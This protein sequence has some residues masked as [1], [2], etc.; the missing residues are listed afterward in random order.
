[1]DF[2]DFFQQGLECHRWNL[3][4]VVVREAFRTTV[5]ACTSRGRRV[6][7]WQ[8]RAFIY[9]LRG[10]REPSQV[11]RA[12][13]YQWPTPTDPSWQ[14]IAFVYRDGTVE[15]DWLHPVSRRFWTDDNDQFELPPHRPG[16]LS[17]HWFRTMGFDVLDEWSPTAS[18]TVG[19]PPR[20]PHLR[21]VP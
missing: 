1:M 2:E 12:V 10:G 17:G 5:R 18:A 16:E 15:L 6:A 11:R 21:I 3:P 8:I 4:R 20:E 19:P 7:T 14:L 13:R 9:G